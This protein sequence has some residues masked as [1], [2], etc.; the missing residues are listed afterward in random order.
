MT[1]RTAIKGTFRDQII[2][3]IM[4]SGSRMNWRRDA[5]RHFFSEHNIDCTF[6]I[7]EMKAEIK[8]LS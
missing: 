5:L 4:K 6:K 2:A 3:I 8:E 1:L 7:S